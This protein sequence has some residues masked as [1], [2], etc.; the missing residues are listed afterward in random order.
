MHARLIQLFVLLQYYIEYR[1]RKQNDR[2]DIFNVYTSFT[3]IARPLS[4][5]V[6][7]KRRQ[8]VRWLLMWTHFYTDSWQIWRQI[9]C[10]SWQTAATLVTALLYL[11]KNVHFLITSKSEVY[12]DG[13]EGTTNFLIDDGCGSLVRGGDEFWSCT[14]WVLHLTCE[15][16][17]IWCVPR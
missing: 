1:K 17:G 16:E 5:F 12:S 15:N 13:A 10:H 6:A 8:K 2:E 4:K 3:S 14:C 9:M 11:K 7:A